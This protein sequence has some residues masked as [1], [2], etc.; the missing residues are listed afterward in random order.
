MSALRSL[1]RPALAALVAVCFLGCST[2]TLNQG[3]TGNK[4]P[5]GYDPNAVDPN[6][7]AMTFAKV[8]GPAWLNVAANGALSGTPFS[9]NVGTNSFLV[10]V[11]DSGSLSNTAT[12]NLV[13]QPGPP[14][15]AS[16]SWQAG[17]LLLAWNGGIPPYQVQV[18]S[19]LSTLSWQNLGGPTGGNSL[20]ITP[21]NG[22][23]FY[24]VVGQ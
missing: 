5:F 14:I 11:I 9:V 24:R 17:N 10:R 23:A 19:N 1:V 21:T 6:G 3:P 12:M 20:L 13:V 4:F 15:T 22:A 16:I 2:D 7:D 18:V 8:S